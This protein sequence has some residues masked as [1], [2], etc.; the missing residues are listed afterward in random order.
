MAIITI[1]FW[2]IFFFFL[3]GKVFYPLIKRFLSIWYYPR[4]LQEP[5]FYNIVFAIPSLFKWFVIFLV[6]LWKLTQVLGNL[7]MTMRYGCFYSIFCVSSSLVKGVSCNLLI[8]QWNIINQMD[9]L[10]Y[11]FQNDPLHSFSNL[12]FVLFFAPEE[13]WNRRGPSSLH[14]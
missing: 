6:W 8:V 14:T 7:W 13:H 1:H 10:Y 4:N 11:V 9:N 5:W 12:F 2:L 3:F